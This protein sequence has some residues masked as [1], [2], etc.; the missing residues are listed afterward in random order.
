MR[1][2]MTIN[3]SQRL[4]LSRPIAVRGL[5]V[6]VA[7]LEGTLPFSTTMRS[8]EMALKIFAFFSN[9]IWL[10]ALIYMVGWV[11]FFGEYTFPREAA[12]PLGFTGS[13]TEH[14]VANVASR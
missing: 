12:S 14:R 2:S 9:V 13:P 10:V 6:L 11:F 7:R 8:P 4:L 3:N 1:P 5:G